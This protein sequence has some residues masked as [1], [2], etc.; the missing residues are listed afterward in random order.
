M[1]ICERCHEEVQPAADRCPH[2]GYEAARDGYWAAVIVQV[3]GLV[4]TL[5]VIGAPLGL[6]LQYWSYRKLKRL[7]SAT[8]GV[9]VGRP[10]SS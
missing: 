7:R 8:V 3:I 9:E 6:P 4:L 1:H 10:K 5:S 2:C